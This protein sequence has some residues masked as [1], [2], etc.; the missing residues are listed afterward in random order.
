LSTPMHASPLAL[1]LVGCVDYTLQDPD[2]DVALP[3]VVEERF[4]QQALPK[5]DVLFVVDSTGSMAG[6]Q[7]SFAAA[8]ADFVGVLDGLA[9]S[10][11]VGV[12]TTDPSDQGALLGRPW[13]ITARNEDPAAALA[14]GLTVGT[15]SPPPAAGLYAAG[16][17]LADVN[18]L[19]RGFHRADAA[20]QVV[21]VSDG[22]DE[23]DA[24][25]AD[26]TLEFVALLAGEALAS[27]HAA[28]ASAV[29]GNTPDGCEGESGSAAPGFRYVAV[30]EA[31]GGVV[32]SICSSNF[33]SVAEALG[34]ASVEWPT[35]F[36]LQ[37]VPVADTVVV[38]V[39]GVRV[40]NW[41]VEGATLLFDAAPAPDAD[42]RVRYELEAAP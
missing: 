24:W 4:V 6:E 1:L 33:V 2:E 5:V 32:A 12:I 22:D 40:S 13:I 29:V 7:A 3:V 26:P 35:S 14:V 15:S 11:Q 18:G 20:L 21:F 28:R 25:A 10:Y 16:L 34:E 8:A 31:T 36:E 41:H 17:A 37:A 42:I 38:D 27:G 19:N 30:A 9:L 39:D 23:S